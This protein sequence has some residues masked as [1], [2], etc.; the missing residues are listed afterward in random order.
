MWRK[1]LKREAFLAAFDAGTK[2]W[3]PTFPEEMEIWVFMSNLHFL[4][5]GNSF[6]LRN[7]GHDDDSCAS[8]KHSP[9]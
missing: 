5:I 4:V 3:R 7:Y 1:M 2:E 9:G 6:L 8:S